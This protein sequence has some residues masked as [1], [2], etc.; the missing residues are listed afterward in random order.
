[1]SS[2][3]PGTP[4]LEQ[5]IGA[6]LDQLV[7]VR[8]LSAHTVKAYRRDLGDFAQF[9]ADARVKSAGEVR[10]AHIRRWLAA[11]HRRGLAPSTQQRR[12]SALRALF[13]WVGREGGERRNPAAAV[14]APRKKRRLPRTLEADELGALLSVSSDDPLTL[15]DLAMAELLY[16]SGLR[17]AELKSLNLSD[18]DLGQ[19]LVVVTGKGRKTRSVPVGS[20][21]L[22]AIEA[23]LKLRPPAG[24]ADGEQALFLSRRGLRISE[25]S[26]QL[27]LQRLAQRVGL[28]RDLHPH[29]LRHSFASHLLESSGD[30]RAVQELLGHS[31][32]STTQIYTHLDFQH[33]AKVYDSAH[34]RASRRDG[35]EKK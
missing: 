6:F 27:R 11:A 26:I 25:R 3:N 22:S 4:S 14:L 19:R 16:S 28:G 34:P 32:I 7:Q 24:N 10:E 9:C 15:R 8:R 29:M 35:E 2:G 33:L 18:L 13:T 21:A 12:L 23:Y 17:L 5:D 31:D 20:A 1:M 30:L